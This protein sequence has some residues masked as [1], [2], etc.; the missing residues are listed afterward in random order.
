M[1]H[2][3]SRIIENDLGR[4]F[5]LFLEPAGVLTLR[6]IILIPFLA[7]QDKANLY[8][9]YSALKSATILSFSIILTSNI[10][11]ESAPDP[12]VLY[13]ISMKCFYFKKLKK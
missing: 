7:L 12:N 1:F 2:A 4:F 6:G 3:G 10:L 5:P 13:N 11:P 8:L 9:T